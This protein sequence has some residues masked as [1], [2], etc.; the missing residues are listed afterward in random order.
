LFVKELNAVRFAYRVAAF[1][2]AQKRDYEEQ[3]A[4]RQILLIFSCFG[5]L[6]YFCAA[7]LSSK[8]RNPCP[9][10]FAARRLCC[11]GGEY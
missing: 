10:C 4:F 7:D 9:V 1:A 6:R 2:A 11:E 8:P 5:K 3:S